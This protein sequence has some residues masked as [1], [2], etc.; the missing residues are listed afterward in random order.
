MTGMDY[1]ESYEDGDSDLPQ[2]SS[3]PVICIPFS[4]HQKK[5]YEPGDRVCIGALEDAYIWECRQFSDKDW[6]NVHSPTS[7]TGYLAWKLI[8]GLP[9]IMDP[10]LS[11]D[12]DDEEEIDNGPKDLSDNEMLAI[13][14]DHPVIDGWIRYMQNVVLPLSIEQTWDCFFAD[15]APYFIAQQMTDMGD[16]LNGFT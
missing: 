5:D 14:D 7:D 10:S 3:E 11:E 13:M 8:D 1:W 12:S 6:C 9:Q 2:I 15:D 16:K 4:H